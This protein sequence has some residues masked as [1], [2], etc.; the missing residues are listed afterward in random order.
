V[1]DA[2]QFS[3]VD[4]LMF[5]GF[6]KLFTFS[7]P[8]ATRPYRG[9]FGP[10]RAIGDRTNLDLAI[11]LSRGEATIEQ[12]VQVSHAMGSGI[13][14][15]VVWTTLG[16]P[17]IVHARIVELLQAHGFTGWSTYPVALVTKSGEAS[18][19][20]VGLTIHGRCGRVDLSR[21][22][23]ELVEYPGGWFPHFKGRFFVPESWDGTDLFME[24][25]DQLGMISTIRMMTGPVRRALEK[26]KVRNLEFCSLMDESV[27]RGVYTI[28]LQHLLPPDYQQRVADAY[29]RAG[30]PRPAR[31]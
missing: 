4:Q 6:E 28:G 31:V 8:M 22:T 16:T 14:G 25:P 24:A 23:I 11:G 26:A 9:M 3:V 15:D 27:D 19:D 7:D 21:S 18:A 13:P 2:H 20:Y 30:V 10:N 12:P 29:A 5:P 1:F 17:L